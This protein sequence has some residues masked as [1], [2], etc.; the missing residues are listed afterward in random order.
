MNFASSSVFVEIEKSLTAEKKSPKYH[1]KKVQP[2]CNT[3]AVKIGVKKKKHDLEL[4]H[5]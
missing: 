2:F 1:L 4:E 3:I 5:F